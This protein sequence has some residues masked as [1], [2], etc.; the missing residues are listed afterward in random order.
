MC[1]NATLTTPLNIVEATY[2]LQTNNS[3]NYNL[4]GENRVAFTHPFLPVVH[5]GRVLDLGKWGLIPNWVNNCTKADEISKMTL[6]AR[7]E[8]ITEKPSFKNYVDK[9]RVVVIFDGFYEW[10][11]VGKDKIKYYISAEKPLLIAGISSTWGG[12]DTFSIITTEAFGIMK[13]IHNTKER[14]PYFLSEEDMDNWLNP[15]IPFKRVINSVEP[16]Y[17]H[18]NAVEV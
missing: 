4:Y 8:T 2:N 12:V 6:N 10:K 1:F 13:E 3:L 15:E 18:L 17:R 16:I 7:V 11:H 5:T 14:M 9:G